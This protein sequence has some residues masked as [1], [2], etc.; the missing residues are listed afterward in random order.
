M[1]NRG[2]WKPLVGTALLSGVVLGGILV[3]RLFGFQRSGGNPMNDS[4]FTVDHVRLT[5]DKP[6]EDV[7]KAVE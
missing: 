4:R 2:H 3:Y 5:T 6:F 7:A 1:A